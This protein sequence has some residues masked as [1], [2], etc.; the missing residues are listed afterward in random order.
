MLLWAGEELEV[1]SM[2]TWG[3]LAGSEPDFLLRSTDSGLSVRPDIA[4]R[5]SSCASLSSL[6]HLAGSLCMSRFALLP[7]AFLLPVS[8]SSPKCQLFATCSVLLISCLIS[9]CTFLCSSLITC[10]RAI[11]LAREGPPLDPVAPLL[12]VI[13]LFRRMSSLPL[14]HT[15]RW[16]ST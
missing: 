10:M 8:H 15:T 3:E 5:E 7:P 12:S 9:S 14:S 1:R 4:R 11:M 16:Q 6:C 13:L 2:E